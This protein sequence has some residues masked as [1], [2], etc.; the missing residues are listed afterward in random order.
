MYIVIRD[1][2]YV[3]MFKML[4]QLMFKISPTFVVPKDNHGVKLALID[5]GYFKSDQYHNIVVGCDMDYY[6][7]KESDIDIN[8]EL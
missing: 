3:S 8:N 1:K 5:N 6:V 7:K 2:N 4:N